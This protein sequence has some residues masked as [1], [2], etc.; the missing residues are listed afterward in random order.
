MSPETQQNIQR[1]W[2]LV[3]FISFHLILTSAWL[4][5]NIM[6]TVHSAPHY[7]SDQWALRSLSSRS[8]SPC[9][10]S[11]KEK[12]RILALGWQENHMGHITVSVWDADPLH[13]PD[14]RLPAL[15]PAAHLMPGNHPLLCSFACW[16]STFY[17]I[18]VLNNLLIVN[19]FHDNESFEEDL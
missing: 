10:K 8:P 14:D 2:G 5:R 1:D 17:I 12:R 15:S 7:T 4:I 6:S 16:S 18:Y 3:L 19:L 11:N 9:P 13:N